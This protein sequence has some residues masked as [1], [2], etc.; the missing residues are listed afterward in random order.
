MMAQATT[1]A[2][3]APARRK[4]I[5]RPRKSTEIVD[6][7]PRQGQ[8]TEADYLALPETNRII[9]LSEGRVVIPDMPT[10]SHQRIVI[11]L[12]RLMSDHVEAQGLGEVCVAPLRVHLWPGKFREP[13][14]V[15]MHRDHADRIGEEYWGVPDLVVEVISPRTQQSS[16]TEHTDRG[17]K[18]V[19]YAKA[20]V[21]EY[22]LIHPTACTIEVYVLR[23]RAYHL[24]DRW[25][26]G[27][28]A[29][30]EVLVGFEVPV[31][32]VIQ[33]GE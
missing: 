15:F 10:T 21:Q 8:W 19:E 27:E 14:I 18:F 28:V 30:S 7:F 5:T 2:S 11:K 24:L 25:G 29:R 23:D 4:Q 31:E 6:L 17:E 1:N 3:V 12:L 9:E 16:G 20:G 32:V 26:K 13:D 33:G 22:W